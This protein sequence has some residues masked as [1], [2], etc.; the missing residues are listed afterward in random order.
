MS[1]ISLV[2]ARL[3]SRKHPGALRPKAGARYRL[4]R[5]ER[6]RKEILKRESNPE[7]SAACGGR[8]NRDSTL[9]KIDHL[10][11]DRQP[12]SGSSS[13]GREEWFEDFLF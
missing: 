6:G 11:C 3:F 5:L 8:L 10:L 7:S 9:V 1:K 12:E 13:F 4:K 2:G